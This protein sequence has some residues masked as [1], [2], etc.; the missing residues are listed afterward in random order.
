MSLENNS[1]EIDRMGIFPAD[2]DIKVDSIFSYTDSDGEVFKFKTAPTANYFKDFFEFYIEKNEITDINQFYGSVITSWNIFTEGWLGAS[3]GSFTDIYEKSIEWIAFEKDQVNLHALYN[4]IEL[5]DIMRK[6]TYSIPTKKQLKYIIDL[7]VKFNLEYGEQPVILDYGCGLA[8]W[9]IKICRCLKEKNIEPRLLL[10]DL[11]KPLHDSFLTF[12]CKKY[13][14]QY[15]LITW[16]SSVDSNTIPPLL[17]FHYC[18]LIDVLEHTPNPVKVMENIIGHAADGAILFA[19]TKD[20][21]P[22]TI[23]HVSCDLSGVRKLFDKEYSLP[24]YSIVERGTMHNPSW[25][26]YQIFK[27]SLDE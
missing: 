27:G 12:L 11:Q 21:K 18:H 16:S 22:D 24:D 8:Q 15:D 25:K 23:Q 20:E 2:P 17:N 6:L 10:I 13:E 19:T 9:S 3:F 1:V 26:L 4:I 14:I 7:L 5:N